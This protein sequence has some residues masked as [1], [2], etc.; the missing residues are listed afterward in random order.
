M[1]AAIR[2]IQRLRSRVYDLEQ[3]LQR[4]DLLAN[5]TATSLITPPTSFAAS[6]A[7]NIAKLDPLKELPSPK[8]FWEGIYTSTA[9]SYETQYYG[10]ASSFYFIG[11]MSSYLASALQQPHSDHHLQLNSASRSF[12]TPTTLKRGSLDD[13]GVSTDGP[14]TADTLSGMQEDYFLGLFWQSYH[15]ILQIID[16]V[17]FKEHYKSLWVAPGKSRKPSA[18]VDIVL[19]LCMQYGV[20]FVPRSG[21]TQQ[22]EGDVDGNDA[23]IAGRWLYRRSQSL[24]SAE[25]ESPTIVTLQCHILAVCYLCNASFQNMAHSTLAIAVRTAQ[26]LGLHLEPPINL[27]RKAKELRRRIWWTL[28]AVESKT[29]MK[30]GRPLSA[31][32]S[33]V[34]CSLPADDPELALLSGS[35][36]ASFGDNV[37]WHSYNLQ[38]TKVILAARA[39]Y[40]SFHDKCA[41]V[42]APSEGTTLYSD[43]HSLEACAQFLSA[44]M[45]C[46]Q[47]WRLEVPDG[48]RTKRK[49]SGESLSTDRSPLDLELYAPVWLQRQRLLLEL[50]YHNLAMNLHRPFISFSN[51]S[52]SSLQHTRGH[53]SA[54]VD[55]AIAI[56]DIMYQM[57][58]ETDTL[59][60]WHEAFQWQWNATLSLIGY[61]LAYPLSPST[62]S[63]RQ[64]ID[65]AIDVFETFGRNFVIAASAANVTRDLTA[66]ADFLIRCFS[67]NGLMTPTIPS[68][69]DIRPLR[70]YN[71]SNGPNGPTGP[72]DDSV[73]ANDFQSVIEPSAMFQ[74]PLAGMDLA[75]TVDSFNSFEPMLAG[76]TN[77]SN[78]W[79]FSQE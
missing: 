55:H 27:T 3:Q 35:S 72:N 8:K 76:S 71:D 16:E 25:L 11:R 13:A 68:S 44:S 4:H 53:A 49:G 52:S 75:F 40:V 12:A 47:T 28:F 45:E 48:L 19:A 79:N 14:T 9:L 50:L 77:M 18:L 32:I 66:K 61:V 31:Q 6:P 38:N 62:L 78:M 57:L 21:A 42:L 67:G 29:C 5:D 60:G 46:L 51:V 43:A 56:T 36:F 70:N 64:A 33:E 22:T 54:C 73:E 7:S 63:A 58:T 2:E 17:E 34:S 15:C 74:N 1:P 20:A 59:R 23:T 10:P 26:I 39:I 41:E 24:L 65:S 30:L 69:G 37:T